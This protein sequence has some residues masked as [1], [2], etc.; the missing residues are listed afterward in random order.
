MFLTGKPK[1]SKIFIDSVEK[2]NIT[3][4]GKN[5]NRDIDRLNEKYFNEAK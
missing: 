5:F 3:I 1:N 4:V 2:A